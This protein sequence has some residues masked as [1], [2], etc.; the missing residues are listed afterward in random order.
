MSQTQIIRASDV[1]LAGVTWSYIAFAYVS[2]QHPLL[3]I[4]ICPFLLLTGSPCP[5]CGSTHFIG[6]LLH[7]VASVN[8]FTVVWLL[9]FLLVA[10]VLTVSS[11]GIAT[12]V[13][14]YRQSSS[15]RPN[16][17]R[18]ESGGPVLL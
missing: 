10:S 2:F 5:L 3:D 17:A 9:W 12:A 18:L 1:A 6:E 8:R 7:G 4:P 15:A 13:W 11:A 16:R 14:Q